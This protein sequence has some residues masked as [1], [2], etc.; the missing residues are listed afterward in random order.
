MCPAVGHET[1]HEAIEDRDSRGVADERESGDGRRDGFQM[2]GARNPLS[3]PNV[4]WN[5]KRR[6]YDEG[7]RF[8]G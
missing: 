4:S 5:G 2:A 6:R 1:E 8:G 7:R 3:D